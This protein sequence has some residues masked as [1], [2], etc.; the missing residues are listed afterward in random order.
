MGLND[1]LA[2]APDYIPFLPKPKPRFVTEDGRRV[3]GVVAEF[4]T[5]ADVFHA[6]EKVRDA[7]FKRWDVNTP[8]PIHDMEEAMG[9]Q[10]TKLPYI[11]FGHALLFVLLAWVMQQFM[12]NWD[13]Y[14]VVQGKPSEDWEAYVPIMFELAVL[15]SAFT[16]LGGMLAFNGLPRFS[17][18]LFSSDR[19]LATSDDRFIIGI[20]ADDPSFDPEQTKKMLA[21]AGG[22]EIDLILD[23]EE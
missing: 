9:M 17:H 21:D 7:G 23:D 15:I 11:V 10:R 22:S 20:E 6:A 4:A 13:Y 14:I 16:A 2:A 18:P 3:H 5:P 1:V 8:F 12:N 19:F